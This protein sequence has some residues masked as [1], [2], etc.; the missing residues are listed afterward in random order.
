[1]GKKDYDKPK[2]V[3]PFTFLERT[4]LKKWKTDIE[5]YRLNFQ[6]LHCNIPLITQLD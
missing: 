3:K 2:K 1:M 5:R 6:I 4:S